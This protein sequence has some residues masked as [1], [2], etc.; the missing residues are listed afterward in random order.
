MLALEPHLKTHLQALPALTG[1]AVR[2]GTELVDRRLLPAV[3]IACDGAGIA[4]SQASGVKI[5]PRWAVTLV[6]RRSDDAAALLDAAFAAVVGSLHGFTPGQHAGRYWS[7]LALQRV[8]A[9]LFGDEGLAGIAMTFSTGA[10]YLAV[11]A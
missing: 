9:P 1:W 11:R 8:E 5:E 10:A 6:V 3:E 7:A 4:S 2:T